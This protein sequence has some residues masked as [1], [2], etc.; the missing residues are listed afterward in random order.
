MAGDRFRVLSL[1][2]KGG[3]GQVMLA[4]DEQ[5]GR[6]VALKEIRPDRADDPENQVRFVA[7]DEITGGLEHPGIVPVYALGRYS[8]QR[9]YYVMRFIRGSHLGKAIDAFHQ[10][11]AAGLKDDQWLLE[12]HKLLRRFID[13]CNAVGYAHSRGVV[14]RDLKPGN[15]MLGKFGETLLVDWGLAKIVGR[16]EEAYTTEEATLR[17][18]AG[19]GSYATLAGS[20]MGTPAYMS[21][22]KAAG[23]LD[24][25]GSA[26]GEFEP[27]RAVN[28]QTPKPLEAI[29]LKAMARLPADSYSSPA[30]L[31]EDLE[32]WMADRPVA[33]YRESRVARLARWMR[34]HRTG[35]RAA[36][37]ALAAVS[38]VSSVAM[39]V[40]WRTW[41]REAAA[42]NQ[43]ATNFVQARE[44]VDRWL[45]GAG[46][47]L[48]YYPAANRARSVLLEQA[49][50][51]YERFVQQEHADPKL[52]LER[53]RTYL[54]LGHLRLMLRD[55]TRANAAYRQ[56][57]AVF[58]GLLIRNGDDLWGLLERANCQTNL[59]AV[60]METGQL[61]QAR[62]HLRTAI[63]QLRQLAEHYPQMAAVRE[64]LAAAVINLGELLADDG[65][66]LDE[67]ERVLRDA[68]A[69]LADDGAPRNASSGDAQQTI[70]RLQQRADAHDLLGRVLLDRGQYEQG[71]AGIQAAIRIADQLIAQEPDNPRHWDWRAVGQVYQADALRVLGRADEE[72][73]ASRQAIETYRRLCTALHGTARRSAVRSEF[74]DHAIELRQPA[75]PVRPHR[76]S[77]GGVER[78]PRTGR[79]AGAATSRFP[80]LPRYAGRLPGVAGRVAA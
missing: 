38:V 17:I 1:H 33:A 8:D 58:D 32:C 6:T 39:L 47:A 68:L 54:R 53:G 61:T 74:G 50:E 73:T 77:R 70:R 78:S 67:A 55:A 56:A 20:K 14:H 51:E 27:P 65:G 75:A 42:W 28:P 40:V 76:G 35:V 79:A 15:V 3:L 57:E 23:D 59:G 46:D 36:V 71:L 48:S 34:R 29:S 4:R 45:T 11:V 5:I 72:A 26:S 66:S 31:V 41:Q 25:L 22:E 30:Q 37:A 24:A 80:G 2:D 12:M 18:S 16:S 63:E 13:V 10:Q 21:P 49:S 19:S 62:D 64:G 44:A 60:A 9:P 43:A 69:Q 52:E 7:E